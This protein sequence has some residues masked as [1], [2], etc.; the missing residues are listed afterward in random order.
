[1]TK[2]PDPETADRFGLVA[3]G[4]D[5]DPETLLLAYSSGI[6]PWPVDEDEELTWFSPAERAVL[7]LDRVK[8][9]RSLAKERRR[10]LF[11]FGI[12]SN[13]EAVIDGCR[14]SFRPYQFGTWITSE[15]R[16]AY[17]RF[18]Q[19]GFAHSIECYLRDEPEA[20]PVGGLYGVAIGAMFAGESMFFK[21]PNASKLSLWFLIERLRAAGVPWIDCQQMTPL[22][23]SF[24][25]VTIKRREFVSLVRE[26]AEKKV[27][28]FPD[29][30][31]NS[32]Y[33][34]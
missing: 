14:E 17:L 29:S 32:R 24:G 27:C 19:L 1:M 13:F 11:C 22:L 26:Q 12:N 3:I 10:G 30:G 31:D 20:E 34:F 5:L 6:F 8:I 21:A 23:A 9:P 18:N 2:F 4:G 33:E 16:E 7:F 28:L 25:A 15:M